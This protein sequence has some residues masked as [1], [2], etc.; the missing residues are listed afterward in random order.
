[1]P[2]AVPLRS[3]LAT[4]AML[5]GTSPL[6]LQAFG[7]AKLPMVLGRAPPASAFTLYVRSV[8]S[9]NADPSDDQTTSGDQTM[10]TQEYE[11]TLVL[12]L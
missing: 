2:K 12:E 11:T 4:A 6:S 8:V 9:M 1:M 5:E 7:V 3:T 10:R